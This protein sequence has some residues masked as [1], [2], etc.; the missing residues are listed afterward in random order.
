[1]RPDLSPAAMLDAILRK[2]IDPP[3]DRVG[4]ALARAGVRADWVTWAGFALGLCAVPAIASKAYLIGLGFILLN[5]LLDGLDGAVARHTRV[6]DAGAF[7]DIAL[8]F[9]FYP[10]VPFAFALA[11]PGEALAAAFLIFSFIASGSSFLAYAAIAAKRGLSTEVRGKKS[12]YHVGGLTEG[13]ETFIAFALAS[14]FPSWFSIICYVFGILCFVTGGTR[15]AAAVAN[16]R[17]P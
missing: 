12:I 15:I 10:A 11:Q 1:M 6:S 8:D 7:L 5:R 16:F 9:I 14:I 2:Q 4:A 13:S 3:L 17:E